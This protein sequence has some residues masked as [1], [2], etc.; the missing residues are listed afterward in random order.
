MD[1]YAEYNAEQ[2]KIVAERLAKVCK[3]IVR[4][5]TRAN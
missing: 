1:K 2:Y 5:A 3:Q 4:A